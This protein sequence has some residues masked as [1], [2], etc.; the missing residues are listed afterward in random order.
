MASLPEQVS[1]KGVKTENWYAWNN[2]M[3]PKPDDFHVVGDIEVSNPGIDPMLV[4]RVPQGINPRILLLNLNLVQQPGAWPR[5]FVTK[6]V[7]YNRVNTTYDQV[8]VFCEDDVIADV[9]VEDVH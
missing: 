5:V 6:Q 3:P 9:N 8:Q 2:L 1:C 4:A 7:R